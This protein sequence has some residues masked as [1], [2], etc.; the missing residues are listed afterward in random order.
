MSA[1]ES[2]TYAPKG[3]LRKVEN[4]QR[5]KKRGGKKEKKNLNKILQESYAHCVELSTGYPAGML[6]KGS[7]EAARKYSFANRRKEHFLS[8][9]R[10][11]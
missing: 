7:T 2:D 1:A 11:F 3:S 8:P 4:N 5:G 9:R 6:K 10:G